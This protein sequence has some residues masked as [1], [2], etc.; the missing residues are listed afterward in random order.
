MEWVAGLGIT[1]RLRV[2]LEGEDQEGGFPGA[3]IPP[4]RS[5]VIHQARVL[6][7]E[8]KSES[9]PRPAK[10]SLITEYVSTASVNFWQSDMN[11]CQRSTGLDIQTS[12]P[13]VVTTTKGGFSEG[14]KRSAADSCD[15]GSFSKNPSASKLR[16]IGIEP[17][18]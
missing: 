2:E 8:K 13:R 12:H 10:L 3:V 17:A 7:P 1:V 18:G 4:R 11:L 5:R 15:I 16:S 14:R 6:M 9:H